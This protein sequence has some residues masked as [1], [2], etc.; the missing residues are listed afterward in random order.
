MDYYTINPTPESEND[1]APHLRS[2]PPVFEENTSP[3]PPPLPTQ[4]SIP[5]PKSVL[6]QINDADK[7]GSMQ[8]PEVKTLS[9]SDDIPKPRTNLD[10]SEKYLGFMMHSPYAA[11]LLNRTLIVPPVVTNSHDKYNSNQRWSDFFDLPRFTSL[12]GIKTVEWHDVRP[13]TE[14]Q[15]EVGRQQARM[16]GKSYPLWNSLAENLTCQVIYGYGDS[17]RLHTTELTFARQF[18]LSP[19]FVRPPPRNPNTTVYDRIKIGAKDNTN[20]DDVVTFEDLVG[21]YGDRQDQLLFLSHAFKLKDPAA[22]GARS[23]VGM[24]FHFLPKVTDYA[25]RLIRHRAPETK[26][27]GGKYIAI[28]IRRGDI[29]QKCRSQSEEAML[30]C[31]IPLGRYAESVDKARKQAGAMLPVIVTTDSKSE[32]DHNT[33]SRMGWRRLNHEVYT[34][35]EELG[36]FGPAMVDA[37]ILANAEVMIGTFVSS[38]SRVAARRQKSWHQREV[39]Y[40]RTTPSWVPKVKA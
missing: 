23:T 40:P 24:N 33:I 34:T 14:E 30:A 2:R 15:I 31:I 7:Q 13:L 22:G 21:R 1:E 4:E 19:Q 29:W 18:L 16:G 37:A 20:L 12:T 35:E 28:H 8:A 10:P 9:L 27:N 6:R 5:E 39:I 17:E 32:E 25:A 36:I 38:M 26:D 11:L 3:P